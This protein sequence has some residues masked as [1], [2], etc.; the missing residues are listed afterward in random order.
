MQVTEDMK[1][2]ILEEGFERFCI[3]KRYHF[4]NLTNTFSAWYKF[5]C[6]MGVVTMLLH[7]LSRD[8][9]FLLIFKAFFILFIFSVC[10]ATSVRNAWA[11]YMDIP[12]DH[13][14]TLEAL[15]ADNC[16]LFGNELISYQGKNYQR[17]LL[18]AKASDITPGYWMVLADAYSFIVDVMP[19]EEGDEVCG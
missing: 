4:R 1:C 11:Y 14:A 10:V 8:D 19:N 13:A 9:F 5:S 7:I 16:R 6:I 12:I 2:M 3:K 18:R 17:L 15:D